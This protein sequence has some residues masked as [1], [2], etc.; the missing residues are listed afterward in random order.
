MTDDA[1]LELSLDAIT[2]LTASVMQSLTVIKIRAATANAI[3][4]HPAGVW[5]GGSINVTP[6]V[7]LVETE[8]IDFFSRKSRLLAHP[9]GYDGDARTLRLNSMRWQWRLAYML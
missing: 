6:V 8:V 3:L 4:A 7:E 5:S 1:T 9:S 2:R